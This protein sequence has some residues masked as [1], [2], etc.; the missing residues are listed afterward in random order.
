MLTTIDNPYNPFSHYD[1]WNAWDMSH[2]Y[3]TNGLLARVVI[4]SDE[5]SEADQLL[6]ID[7]GIDQIIQDN[8]S[9]MHVRISP[10]GR[11]GLKELASSEE[12]S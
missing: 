3:Y 4:T 7:Y 2:G 1:E 5:I 6:A 11:V 8:P 10:D 12:K 9:G